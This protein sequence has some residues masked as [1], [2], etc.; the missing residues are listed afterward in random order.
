L[1]APA[2]LAWAQGASA[3]EAAIDPS[4]QKRGGR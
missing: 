2:W 1:T 4:L 3:D